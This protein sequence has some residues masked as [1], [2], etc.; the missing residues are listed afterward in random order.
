M[1]NGAENENM[2]WNEPNR[3]RS[4]NEVEKRKGHTGER[5]DQKKEEK[6]VND[7]QE[8]VKVLSTAN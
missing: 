3:K 4:R 6:Q 2:R 7:R 8:M 5:V 1:K